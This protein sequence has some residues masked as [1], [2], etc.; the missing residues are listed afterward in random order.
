MEEHPDQNQTQPQTTFARFNLATEEDTYD[1]VSIENGEFQDR[2]LCVPYFEDVDEIESKLRVAGIR[3]LERSEE[4][5][6][7]G[8]I[9]YA[10]PQ[11]SKPLSNEKFYPNRESTQTYVS[12][13][14]LYRRLGNLWATTFKA[15]NMLPSENPLKQTGMLEFASDAERLFPI[16]PYYWREVDEGVAPRHFIDTLSRE[17]QLIDPH[18]Q[19]TTLIDAAQAG[20]EE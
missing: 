1:L 17:L 12:D 7:E 18:G 5:I 4:P 9:V 6:Q 11:Q 15:T 13:N 20:W 8:Y 16:P 14:E 3:L 19:H 2:Y 10:V